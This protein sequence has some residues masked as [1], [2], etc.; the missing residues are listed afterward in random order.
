MTIEQETVERLA[1]E[2][3]TL[4]QE[5]RRLGGDDADAAVAT[6]GWNE[7]VATVLRALLAERDAALADVAR[8]STPPDDAEVR[9]LVKVYRSCA[10]SLEHEPGFVLKELRRHHEAT[11]DALT[12]LSHALA[13]ETAKREAMEAALAGLIEHAHNCE[14]ELTEDLHHVD[15]CGESLPLTAARATLAKHGSKT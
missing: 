3:E 4:A 6:A 2:N 7:W 8:L 5:L 15:F 12:R 1:V 9:A 11:A 14:R 13:A 10:K